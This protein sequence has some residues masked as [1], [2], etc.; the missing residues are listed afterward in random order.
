MENQDSKIP[1]AEVPYIEIFKFRP[2]NKCNAEYLLVYDFS[3]E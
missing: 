1:T 3:N 2:V